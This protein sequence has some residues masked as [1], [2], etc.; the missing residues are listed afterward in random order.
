MKLWSN[1]G[2]VVLSPFAGI[3]SEGAVAITMGRRFVGVEL[4]KSYFD[5][6]VSNL[7]NPPGADD[8][9]SDISKHA[10]SESEHWDY[11]KLCAERDALSGRIKTIDRKREAEAKAALAPVDD[12]LSDLI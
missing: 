10:L 2:D 11:A 4:K 9:I 7:E 1:P 8:V 5:L 12:D 3:G 6:A